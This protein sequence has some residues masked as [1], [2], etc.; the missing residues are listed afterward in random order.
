MVGWAK[1]QI[2]EVMG[3][4]LPSKPRL[5]DFDIQPLSAGAARAHTARLKSNGKEV[6]IKVIRP[7]IIFCRYPGRPETD[8]RLALAAI[9]PVAG[10]ASSASDGSGAVCRQNADR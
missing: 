2:E 8:Y 4:P 7:D 1:A 6:V 5:D 3:G 9:T 10:W